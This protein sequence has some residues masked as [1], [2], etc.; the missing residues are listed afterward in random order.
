[1]ADSHLAHPLHQAQL[2]AKA[3]LTDYQAGEFIAQSVKDYCPE[4]T[5]LILDFVAVYAP[6]PA[7]TKQLA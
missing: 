3:G 7:Q 6:T 5:Q 2:E 1:M 4:H